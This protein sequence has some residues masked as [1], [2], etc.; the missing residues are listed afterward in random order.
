MVTQL[1]P[2]SYMATEFKPQVSQQSIWKKKKKKP[3][4]H[5]ITAWPVDLTAAAVQCLSVNTSHTS[6]VEC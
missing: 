5:V 2:T 1:K 3:K 6:T 4:Q